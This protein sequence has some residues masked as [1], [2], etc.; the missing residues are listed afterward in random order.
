MHQKRKNVMDLS[1]D[2]HIVEALQSLPVPLVT[3]DGHEVYFDED[4][5][6]ETI[7]EHI[8]NKSHHLHVVDILKIPEILKDQESLREDKNGDKFRNYV[9]RRGKKNES[10]QYL[11][12]TTRL[13]NDKEESVVTVYLIKNS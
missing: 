13:K 11:Q 8:A 2:I 5:R 6:N 12:I 7:F 9:G 1:Y 10:P 3:F 4:K